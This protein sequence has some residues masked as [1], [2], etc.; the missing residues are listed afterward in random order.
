MEYRLDE[1]FD[2]LM[3][4]TPSRDKTE[5]WVSEGNKWISISDMSRCGKYISVTKEYI[6]DLAVTE[7]GISLIPA[8]TVIMSFKLSIGKTAIT[9]EPMYSNEAIMSFRD[10]NVVKLIPDYVYYWLSAKNWEDET[11]KAVLGNTLNKSTLS[12]IRIQVP[13]YYEQK[14]VVEVLDKAK[15]LIETRKKE[16]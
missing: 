11:N 16:L 7:S 15:R 8:N 13:S 12:S 9:M 14:R 1:L 10:K 3:G 4:K 5:Y 2:L 6:S